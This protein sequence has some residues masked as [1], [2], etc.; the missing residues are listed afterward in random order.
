MSRS[1]EYCPSAVAV[2]VAVWVAGTDSSIVDL[3]R[4]T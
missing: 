2:Q 4:N 3:E 1:V